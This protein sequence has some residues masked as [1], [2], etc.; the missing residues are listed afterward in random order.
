M[1]KKLIFFIASIIFSS[2]M[3]LGC[4]HEDASNLQM[5]AQPQINKQKNDDNIVN[6]DKNSGMDWKLQYKVIK[7]AKFHVLIN[8]YIDN[9][10]KDNPDTSLLVR[11][12]W[13]FDGTREWSQIY[14]MTNKI[15]LKKSDEIRT[16][17]DF[18]NKIKKL[19]PI[20]L[21]LMENTIVSSNVLNQWNEQV[22]NT[23][24][25]YSKESPKGLTYE[26]LGKST[27]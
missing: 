2:L 13:C 21:K 9:N 12:Y 26:M 4:S 11:E 3:L 15:V 5:M 27:Q 18:K 10:D 17:L 23:E 1:N 8:E 25:E 19:N 22:Y 20:S 7:T 6:T 16:T 24:F 14:P